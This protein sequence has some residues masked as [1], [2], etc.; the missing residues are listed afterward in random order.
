MAQERS[1]RK[2]I[3]PL[4]ATSVSFHDQ[5][6]IESGAA[7]DAAEVD[8]GELAKAQEKREERQEKATVKQHEERLNRSFLFAPMWT[9]TRQSRV[10][11]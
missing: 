8:L 5:P 3:Y 11:L 10:P 1:A 2:V 9:T 4:I 6:I 7:R